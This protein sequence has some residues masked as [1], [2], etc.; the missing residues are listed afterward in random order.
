MP[1][2]VELERNGTWEGDEFQLATR[3]DIFYMIDKTGP[4][5]ITCNIL[6]R[7]RLTILMSLL[8]YNYRTQA[9]NV[10]PVKTNLK[11]IRWTRL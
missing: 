4:T 9:E 3:W 2:L 8:F 5:L 7:R 1:L 10:E 6:A 11:G